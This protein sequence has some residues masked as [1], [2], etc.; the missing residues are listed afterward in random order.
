M[1]IF[2]TYVCKML[3]QVS[4][5]FLLLDIFYDGVKLN[6]EK[7]SRITRRKWIDAGT[8]VHFG[9]CN[10]ISEISRIVAIKLLLDKAYGAFFQK[11]ISKNIHCKYY[12]I[13]YSRGKNFTFGYSGVKRI[14]V[15]FMRVQIQRRSSSDWIKNVSRAM[16][17]I[18][19]RVAKY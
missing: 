11:F 1:Q 7:N 4:M 18:S 19:A 16:R 3:I 2:E 12:T 13:V 10:S 6:F 15:F 14:H 5:S 9:I 8:R 17:R